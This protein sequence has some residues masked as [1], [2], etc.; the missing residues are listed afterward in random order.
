V[1]EP[2]L[3]EL[4]PL[5]PLLAL[6]PLVLLVLGLLAVLEGLDEAIWPLLLL[7]PC[8]SCHRVGKVSRSREAIEFLLG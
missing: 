5:L 7:M 2:V 1:L 8:S 4:L 3:V 6:S